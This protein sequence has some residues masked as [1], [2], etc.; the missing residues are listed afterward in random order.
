MTSPELAYHRAHANARATGVRCD[1][2]PGPEEAGCACG[3]PHGAPAAETGLPPFRAS[4]LV[5]LHTVPLQAW[6]QFQGEEPRIH[7]VM[8]KDEPEALAPATVTHFS[9]TDAVRGVHNTNGSM[10]VRQLT[11][12][13]VPLGVLLI[14]ARFAAQDRRIYVHSRVIDRSTS[15]CVRIGEGG[16]KLEVGEEF[17]TS[18]LVRPL[19]DTH[20]RAAEPFEAS[21]PA[22]SA[23][24]ELTPKQRLFA[25]LYGKR[26]EPDVPPPY[27]HLLDHELEW[28]E[29]HSKADAEVSSRDA[30]M[31]LGSDAHTA[32]DYANAMRDF[33]AFTARVYEV[34]AERCARG[35]EPNL[36]R[37]GAYRQKAQVERELARHF[38]AQG[39]AQ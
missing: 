8:A 31:V 29:D 13:P 35:E 23:P 34:K 27:T 38:A 3:Q 22:A 7:Q 33:H 37:A 20:P 15:Y 36:V 2:A 4:S 1:A 14:G 18:M 11:T 30:E 16:K 19:V 6:F 24:S 25:V 26:L 39:G 5:R 10:L 21:R 32:V 28:I 9:P 12:E 17:P